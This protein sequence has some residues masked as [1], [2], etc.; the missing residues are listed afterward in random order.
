MTRLLDD[1]LDVS[2]IT[3]RR[4]DLRRQRLT[5]KHVIDRGLET[6]RPLVDAA[7][8]ALS[9]ELPQDDVWLDGDPLRLSQVVA[10]L[11]NNAAKYTS[12]R[13]E[14]SVRAT[15]DGDQVVIAVRDDGI[16]I[17]HDDLARVFDVFAQ[18]AP[19]LER[20]HGG[21]G[22]GLSLVRG[23]VEAHGG[24]VEAHSEGPGHGSEFIVRLPA[25]AAPAPA[26]VDTPRRDGPGEPAAPLRI[27]VADD[28]ADALDSLTLLLQRGGHEVHP[29]PD[30]S[31]AVEIAERVRPDVAL[32][33]IGMP[34]LNGYE[35]A[36]R[37]RAEDWGRAMV[38][39]ALT[40]WGQQEDRQRALAAGFDDHLVKPVEPSR[41]A[42]LLRH[43][44]T[45]VGERRG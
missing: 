37:I 21:L 35:T 22:I 20:S 14:I 15:R 38:L 18:A 11:V 9:I 10:N 16:G 8:H 4:L 2:R 39:V 32:L 23:I 28:N 17:A 24:T 1:L 29:A 31:A 27:L 12:S 34:V 26:Q 45:P 30:G 6:S 33:D 44:A 41:L 7:G 25:A 40:G 19:A 13:G 43:I 42:T 5:L 36:R 3:R